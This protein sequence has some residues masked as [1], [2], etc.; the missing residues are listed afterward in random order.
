MGYC[1]YTKDSVTLN[2]IPIKILSLMSSFDS[3]PFYKSIKD[4]KILK[5]K[6]TASEPKT[7][8]FHIKCNW[9]EK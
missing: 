4:V 1:N 7:R 2:K 6:K 5:E 3:L 8:I 9:D